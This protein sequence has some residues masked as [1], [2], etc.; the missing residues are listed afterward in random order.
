[1]EAVVRPITSEPSKKRLRKLPQSINMAL[2]TA[3]NIV[4]VSP[5]F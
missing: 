3:E 4:D 5:S 1:M 2:E